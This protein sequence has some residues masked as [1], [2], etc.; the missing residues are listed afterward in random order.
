MHEHWGA[1]DKAKKALADQLARTPK[2]TRKKVPA[3]DKPVDGHDSA[4]KAEISE[5]E[6]EGTIVQLW[7][8]RRRMMKRIC[9]MARRGP[10]RCQR[11]TCSQRLTCSIEQKDL[12]YGF[13]Q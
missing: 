6:A 2:C 11:N 12:N 10:L 8:R 1:R 4:D 7:K 9:S 13:K 5:A 3:D